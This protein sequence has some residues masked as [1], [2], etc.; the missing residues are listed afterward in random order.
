MTA[1]TWQQT[2]R[3]R[4]AAVLPE[5]LVVLPVG[6]VEQHGPHLPTGTDAMIAG[7]VAAAAVQRA[8]A[9]APRDLVLAPTVPF[10]A[11]D[12][13]FAFG[14]TLSLSP[15]T[16]TAVLNDLARSVAADGGRRLVLVNGHGGNR[17]PCHSAAAS[18]ATR[19]GLA[20]AYLD[21][22][23]LFP[24]HAFSADPPNVPGHA[25][26]FESALIAHLHPELVGTLPDRAAQPAVPEAANVT[27]HT[28]RLWHT[29]DG[30]TDRPAAATG[31]DGAAWFGALADALADRLVTL[32]RD[33]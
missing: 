26:R 8:A 22:W 32:A 6:T 28:P 25:G 33:L 27:V 29:I 2:D 18:A 12:H 21:Y 10:G 13:H 9:D 11:S 16:T 4:L 3:D 30:Y 7:A 31:T 19:H 1:W 23:E 5:A 14:A 20:V 15:E 17:G 24:H